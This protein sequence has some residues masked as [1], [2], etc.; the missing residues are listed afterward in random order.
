MLRS[1]ALPAPTTRRDMGPTATARKRRAPVAAWVA[2]SLPALLGVVAAA[3]LGLAG[4]PAGRLGRPAG[5]ARPSAQTWSRLPA[6]ARLAVSRSLG[7][8]E[9]SYWARAMGGSFALHNAAQGLLASFSRRGAVIE[10]GGRR[11]QLSLWGFGRRLWLTP[12][13]PVA[14][15]AHANRVAFI[16]AGVSE[17]YANGPL[18]L[19]Q[20]FTIARAPAGAGGG[21]LTLA[22]HLGGPLRA[23]LDPGARGATFLAPNG[24]AVLRYDSLS[25]SDAN[26]R[27]LRAWL[28]LRRGLMLL[29]VDARGAAY[30][31]RIDPLFQNAELTAADGAAGDALGSSVAVSGSTIAVGAPYHTIAG[32][33]RQGAVYVFTKPASGWQNATQIAELTAS[34]GQEYDQLGTSVAIDGGTIVAGAPEHTYPRA[35]L[36]VGETSQGT[37][38]V[39]TEPLSGWGDEHQSA[40]LAMPAGSLGGLGWSVAAS[41]STIVAGAFAAPGE[42]GTEQDGAAYVFTEPP[43]GWTTSTAS[44]E[45]TASDRAAGDYFGWSVAASG[46]TIVV[47][48]PGHGESGAAYVFAE[49][50]GGWQTATQTAELTPSGGTYGGGGNPVTTDPSVAIEGPTIAIAGLTSATFPGGAVYVFTEPPSGWQS[51]SQSAT[52]TPSDAASGGELLGSVAISGSTIVAGGRTSVGEEG[53]ALYVFTEPASGWRSETESAQLYAS[54]G[55]A[56]GGLGNSVAI[57]GAT[58]VGGA[59]GHEVSEREQGAAYVFTEPASGWETNSTT[60]TT[61][62]TTTSTKT[63]GGAGGEGTA[64]ASGVHASGTAAQLQ[65]RCEGPPG[66]SCRVVLTLRVLETLSGHRI[67]DVAAR[68]RRGG[69]G[70]RHRSKKVVMVGRAAVTLDA[71]RRRT[72]HVRLNA[73]GRRLLHARRTLE[74]S[75]TVTQRLS[76]GRSR[77]ISTRTLT[78]RTAKPK[79]RG[80][81]RRRR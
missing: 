55:A 9:R 70:R 51:A 21:P 22:L 20:G 29:A 72:A 46:S 11:L 37:V 75:L 26:G 56:S 6:P 47:G 73:T 50:A 69:A 76:A 8:D 7:G 64:I 52:L 54:E 67:I 77:V 53:P 18:G 15:L 68:R 62:T 12:S 27:P 25:A 32:N 63:T 31:L 4:A 5:I 42:H 10:A 23:R 58:I 60:T 61:S 81:H 35:G 16:H 36:P 3:V 39:F 48:A 45:L 78:F 57:S 43:G 19:E 59:S 41:G 33:A 71:G 38:Y 79:A 65:L 2:L 17:W 44:A 30:P 28:E 80:Q 24:G 40:E 1:E 66:V 49:P 34:D 74:V 14:P 13:P